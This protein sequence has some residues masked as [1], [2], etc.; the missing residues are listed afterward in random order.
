MVVM[1]CLKTNK[2]ESDID[3][4]HSAKVAFHDYAI[5]QILGNI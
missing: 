2:S 3:I 1:E 5:L 4:F